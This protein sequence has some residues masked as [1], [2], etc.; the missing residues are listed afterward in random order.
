MFT[1]KRIE[2]AESGRVI[3]HVGASEIRFLSHTAINTCCARKIII[4]HSR[5]K[6]TRRFY[7]LKLEYQ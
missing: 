3:I 7:F 5:I 2:P 6:T 4:D 1:V